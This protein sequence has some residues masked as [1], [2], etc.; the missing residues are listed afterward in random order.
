MCV[1]GYAH[2]SLVSYESRGNGAGV[3]GSCQLAGMGSGRPNLE[4][5]YKRQESL[6]SRVCF[7]FLCHVTN[8][9][10]G[11][12]LEGRNLTLLIGS[13]TGRLALC[14]WAEYGQWGRRA[15]YLLAGVEAKGVQS[16]SRQSLSFHLCSPQ[17]P[18][19]WRAS[20]ALRACLSS[21]VNFLWKHPSRHIQKCTSAVS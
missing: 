3:L 21:S 9:N 1:E 17:P 2:V 13:V 8:N 18:V 11:E 14:V 6:L 16:L 12:Q 7:L 19:H 5:L 20:P 4:P 10:P 15:A